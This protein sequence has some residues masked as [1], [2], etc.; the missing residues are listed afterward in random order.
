MADCAE[1]GGEFLPSNIPPALGE[2]LS[3][4]ARTLRDSDEWCVAG[5][6]ACAIVTHRAI[7]SVSRPK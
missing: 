7:T 1:R 2:A 4:A 6:A 5:L 3:K